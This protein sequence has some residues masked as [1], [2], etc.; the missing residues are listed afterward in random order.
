MFRAT[1][2]G[3]ADCVEVLL[4]R[5]ADVSFANRKGFTPLHRAVMRGRAALVPRLLAAGADLDARDG[6]RKRPV[7]YSRHAVIT[8]ALGGAKG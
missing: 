6:D 5:G 8:E 1:N 3:H 7:E 2:L 4:A